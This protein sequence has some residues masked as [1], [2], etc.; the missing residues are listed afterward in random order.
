MKKIFLIIIGLFFFNLLVAQNQAIK[1]TNI[2]TNKEKI[3]KENKRIKLKTF[4]GQKVKGRFKIENNS[5]I[6]VDNVRIDLSDID[7]LK[8]NPLL[9]SIFTSGFLIYGGAIA[10]GFGV[11]IGVLVDST[12]F[13]LTIP[14]AGMIYTGIKSPNFNKNHKTDKGWKFEII[15]ISD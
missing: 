2:N 14:A 3:I 10:A 8:R 13:W 6:I 5:T 1:I 11:L 9:T 15:T 12:A 7:A 4:D